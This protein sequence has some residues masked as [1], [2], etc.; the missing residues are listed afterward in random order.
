MVMI[1]EQIANDANLV[2]SH[3][4]RYR[5]Q[6]MIRMVW[7]R[8]PLAISWKRPEEW[9]HQVPK[10][11]KAI[12]R[13]PDSICIDFFAS[14]ALFSAAFCSS[15]LAF[16]VYLTIFATRH[17]FITTIFICHHFTIAFVKLLSSLLMPNATKVDL[18]YLEHG[19]FFQGF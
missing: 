6:W 18:F 10:A 11:E 4:R 7:H 17:M 9:P 5:A 1:K 19:D 2:H 13:Q 14:K 12:R 16:A 8:C 3:S 15:L